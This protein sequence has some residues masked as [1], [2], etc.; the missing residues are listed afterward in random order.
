M[1]GAGNLK[2]SKAGESAGFWK[3]PR[4]RQFIYCKDK[5]LQSTITNYSG[6]N[7]QGLVGWGYVRSGALSRLL[8]AKVLF[9][10]QNSGQDT[11]S[12]LLHCE[13]VPTPIQSLQTCYEDT[14]K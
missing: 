5:Y 4:L 9:P 11:G 2:G 14:Q 6:L 1:A 10:A 13:A 12:Q 3:L 7:K 8:T